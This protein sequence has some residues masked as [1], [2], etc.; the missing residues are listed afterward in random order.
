[1]HMAI[2]EYFDTKKLITLCDYHDLIIGLVRDFSTLK[3]TL[4]SLS[5]SWFRHKFYIFRRGQPRT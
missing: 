4:T 5:N 1:M 2:S 3:V